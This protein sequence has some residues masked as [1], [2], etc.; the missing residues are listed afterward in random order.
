MKKNHIK[1]SITSIFICFSLISIS[2]YAQPRK[3]DEIK[4]FI[5]GQN[6]TYKEIPEIPEKWKNESAVIVL[7]KYEH[8][9]SKFTPLFSS[10]YPGISVRKHYITR[11][12]LKLND[13]AAVDEFSELEFH[14]SYEK[15]RFI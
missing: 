4:E 2:G 9:Y 8:S 12:I 15:S 13:K 14:S 7:E 3:A 5:W 11:R 6:D 10:S 1:H